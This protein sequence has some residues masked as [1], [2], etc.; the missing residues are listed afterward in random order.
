MSLLTLGRCVEQP[1]ASVF[2]LMDMEKANDQCSS[3]LSVA[4][5][6]QSP[7]KSNFGE[8]GFISDHYSRLQSIIA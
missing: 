2:S 8:I 6:K 5:V 1:S 3:F 4:M 7:D